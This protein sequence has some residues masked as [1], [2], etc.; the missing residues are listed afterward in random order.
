[1]RPFPD[2]YELIGF[3]ESEPEVLDPNVPWAYNELKFES[4]ASNGVLH[5]VMQTGTEVLELKWYQDDQLIVYLDLVGVSQLE[6][7]DGRK[8]PAPGRFAVVF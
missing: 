6:I 8:Y 2:D 7:G 4:K 3:F 1:M 5:T